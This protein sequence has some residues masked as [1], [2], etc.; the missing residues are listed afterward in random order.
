MPGIL[1]TIFYSMNKATRYIIRR[2]LH[3]LL[4]LK[5]TKRLWHIPLL[6]TLSVGVPLLTGLF[7]GRLND[8]ILACQAD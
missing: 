5:K 1:S 8:G 3:A 7:L 2:E 4:E 6:A